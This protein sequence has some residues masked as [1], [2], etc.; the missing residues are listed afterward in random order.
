MTNAPK[1]DELRQLDGKA[2]FL[3]LFGRGQSYR[4]ARR[5]LL[6]AQADWLREQQAQGKTV[7]QAMEEWRRR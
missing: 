5:D 6:A 3:R 2:K 1:L 7:A 4:D